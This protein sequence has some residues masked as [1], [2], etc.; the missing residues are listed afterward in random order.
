MRESADYKAAQILFGC[1]HGLVSAGSRDTQRAGFRAADPR[2]GR[3]PGLGPIDESGGQ[4]LYAY[5][6]GDPVNAVDL[7]GLGQAPPKPLPWPGPFW[8]L[9]VPNWGPAWQNQWNSWGCRW[10]DQWNQFLNN[11]NKL[12]VATQLNNAAA[13]SSGGH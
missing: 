1:V 9:W 2:G 5:V 8:W 12:N 7:A 11:L 13:A 10:G 4:N 3:W 6:G